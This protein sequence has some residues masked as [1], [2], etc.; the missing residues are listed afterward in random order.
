MIIQPLLPP[1]LRPVRLKTDLLN[2]RI[3]HRSENFRQVYPDCQ[4]QICFLRV[5]ICGNSAR[6]RSALF[7]SSIGQS[8]FGILLPTSGVPLMLIFPKVTNR[9][10]R[11]TDSRLIR[12]RKFWM[13]SSSPVLMFLKSSKYLLELH[14]GHLSRNWP[15]LVA[16]QLDDFPGGKLL[17]DYI[18]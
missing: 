9:R 17:L 2:Y 10:H 3:L 5:L 6:Y 13:K 8:D 16:L 12:T 4:Y 1:L 11:E 15:A 14:F 18:K 7:G